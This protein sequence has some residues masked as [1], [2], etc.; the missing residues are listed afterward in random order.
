MIDKEA[1]FGEELIE[2]A[3]WISHYYLCTLGE[4]VFSMIPSGRRESGAAGF[5]FEEE[6]GEKAVP[7]LS[8]EQEKAV[9]EIFESSCRMESENSD[10][11][12]GVCGCCFFLVVYVKSAITE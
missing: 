8:E 1:L 9:N 12:F 3:R 6:V 4:A 11:S 7:K 5:S 2:I 10:A